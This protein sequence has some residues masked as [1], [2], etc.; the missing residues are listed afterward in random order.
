[1][2]LRRLAACDTEESSSSPITHRHHAG[3]KAIGIRRLC[4]CIWCWRDILREAIEIV[5]VAL[6]AAGMLGSGTVYGIRRSFLDIAPAYE[7]HACVNLSILPSL[8]LLRR[9][10]LMKR[11]DK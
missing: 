3:E 7:R 6:A 11:P 9:R 2:L 8:S 1:M 10:H 5:V 4:C